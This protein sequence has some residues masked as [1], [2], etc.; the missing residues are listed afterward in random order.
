MNNSAHTERHDKEGLQND[1]F[2]YKA[3]HPNA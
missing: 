3:V 1:T 2:L